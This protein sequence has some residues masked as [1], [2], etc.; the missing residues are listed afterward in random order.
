MSRDTDEKEPSRQ[1]T[2][3]P[4]PRFETRLVHAGANDG[5]MA[6]FVTPPVVHASTVL[7]PNVET[8][9][10]GGQRW[11]Y[12]RRGTPT[13]AALESA[14]NAL[15]GA[16]GTVLLPSGLAACAFAVLAL[17]KA[18]DH[19]LITDSAYGPMR[20]FA[21]NTLVRMGVRVEYYDPAIG[22]GIAA[23][24]KPETAVIYLE[25]PGSLTFEMQDVPAIAALARARGI[26]TV[27]DNTWASPYFFR[28]LEHGVD[29]VVHA[30]TKYIVGH[31]DA[32]FG[33]ISANADTFGK[34]RAQ[35]GDM[36]MFAGPDDIYL[37]MRGL[38]TL[39]VRLDRHF[40]SA[41]RVASWLEQQPDVL[42]VLYPALA[43]DPG[44]M[45][46]KRDFSGASGLLGFIVGDC[47]DEA[48][49]AFLDGLE[50]FG[51]GYSWGGFESLASLPS[52]NG[53]RTASRWLSGG[54]LI[55]LHIGLENVED[56]IEDLA[57]G[58]Q[59]MRDLAAR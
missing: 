44:H 57:A 4:G 53:I 19:V 35:H 15:E 33:I 36:G 12:G 56:L 43:S 24:I 46:W 3:P 1:S 38:K 6:P 52:L 27:I 45:L 18:G 59:R 55:R 20:H 50:F 8:M 5:E 9:A 7:F 31:S 28:P 13:S 48:V 49:H 11:V 10:K 32:M 22:A 17:V 51:L 42:R 25:A 37:A 23:L 29:V 2:V 58:L 47:P 30:G 34:I 40:A 26:R 54:R 21:D 16:A 14:L 41:L 39:A